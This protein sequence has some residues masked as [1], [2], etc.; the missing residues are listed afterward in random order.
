[1]LFRN[2]VE[3]PDID[4]RLQARLDPLVVSAV[5]DV[6]TLRAEISEPRPGLM[7]TVSLCSRPSGEDAFEV[8]ATPRVSADVPSRAAAVIAASTRA[9][10][11]V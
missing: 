4:V 5:S 7:E 2:H 9:G 11:A 3:E 10:S 1:M 6:A 8:V